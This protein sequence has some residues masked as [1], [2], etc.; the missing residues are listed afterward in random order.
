MKI[1]KSSQILKILRYYNVMLIPLK[2]IDMFYQDLAIYHF[3][4][5][6]NLY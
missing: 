5:Q 1:A 2:V 4:M 3:G 6:I